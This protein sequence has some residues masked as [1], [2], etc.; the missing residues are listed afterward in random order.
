MRDLTVAEHAA[1]L[2]GNAI[3]GIVG[4]LSP[5]VVSASGEVAGEAMMLT[6]AGY[7]YFEAL[8]QWCYSDTYEALLTCLE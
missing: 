1:V 2:G 7:S 6:A 4:S 3:A 5:S 8:G